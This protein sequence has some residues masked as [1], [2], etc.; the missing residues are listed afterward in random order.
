[1]ELVSTVAGAESRGRETG[2][3]VPPAPAS[4][5]EFVDLVD[6]LVADPRRH[7]ELMDLLREDHPFYN[8]RGAATVVQMRGWVL[9]GLARAGMS[10]DALVFILEELDAGVDPYLVAAAAYALRSS[11]GPNPVLAPFVMRALNQIR[12]HDDPVSF[13]AYADYSSGPAST[14]P[15]REL[16]ITL[17]WLGR[18]ASSVLP[19]LESIVKAGGLSKKALIEANR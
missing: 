16:L 10:D 8:E 19:E 11:A 13:L 6:A 5:D 2:L 17:A 12:Y 15:V 14:S 4:E 1:M 18:H 9:L 3:P 7:D